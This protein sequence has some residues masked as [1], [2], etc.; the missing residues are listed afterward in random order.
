MTRTEFFTLVEA[1]LR[2]RHVSFDA[3]E[4]AAFVEDVGDLARHEPDA[5]RWAEAFLVAKEGA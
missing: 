5:P 3:A 4:L 1:D 2:L